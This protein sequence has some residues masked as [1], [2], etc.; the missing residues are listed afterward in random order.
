MRSVLRARRDAKQVMKFIAL[1]MLG[2]D[3]ALRGTTG[4]EQRQ[5]AQGLF[6]SYRDAGQ[7]L[8][9]AQLE[10]RLAD[11]TAAYMTGYRTA[12]LVVA[13]YAAVIYGREHQGHETQNLTRSAP[14]YLAALRRTMPRV[15]TWRM[16]AT[17][18]VAVGGSQPPAPESLDVLVP[19]HDDACSQIPTQL[20][21]I[22]LQAELAWFRWLAWQE[23]LLPLPF[24]RA[25]PVWL[26][27]AN[28]IRGIPVAIRHDLVERRAR[29]W[30]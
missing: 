21:P 30:A 15:V 11:R 10:P 7:R 25:S 8:A 6:D 22:P 19:V 24:E 5:V 14:R 12:E 27:V 1:N 23:G 29:R 28:G 2:A 18:Q 4:H 9:P 26:G 3:Q 20:A 17:Y 13:G 16:G